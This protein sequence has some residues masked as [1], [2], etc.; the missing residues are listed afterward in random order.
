MIAER[1]N[2]NL[3]EPYYDFPAHED[4]IIKEFDISHMSLYDDMAEKV[5][6]DIDIVKLTRTIERGTSKAR[7][8]MSTYTDSDLK[9]F[10]KHLFIP[11]T[12]VKKAD[13]ANSLMNVYKR[14]RNVEN[15]L[16]KAKYVKEE[17]EKFDPIRLLTREQLIAF[18]VTNVDPYTLSTLDKWT[19]IFNMGGS[20][21]SY[22]LR[23]KLANK[24]YYNE[25]MFTTTKGY[26]KR[27]TVDMATQGTPKTVDQ[28][29][30]ELYRAQSD[31]S[32]I[33]YRNKSY[34]HYIKIAIPSID[35]KGQFTGKVYLRN[36]LL[37]AL[38]DVGWGDENVPDW[39][40]GEQYFISPYDDI[41]LQA[42]L[43]GQKVPIAQPLS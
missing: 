14:Y 33:F 22:E 35:I 21:S 10:A 29:Y 6:G 26:I 2:T 37:G 32:D 12:K 8:V 20:G 31:D 42:S 18:G 1:F 39:P 27:M 30:D 38:E 4:V 40:G 23:I 34:Y 24:Y 7:S 28:V 25:G 36:L 17:D 5:I 19:K 3:V 13:T 11:T 9:T 16:A 15:E 43:M 41:M